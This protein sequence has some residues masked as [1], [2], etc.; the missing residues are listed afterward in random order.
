MWN[1]TSRDS[2]TVNLMNGSSPV[3]LTKIRHCYHYCFQ[4]KSLRVLGGS[5]QEA[6][7]LEAIFKISKSEMVTEM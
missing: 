6:P 1:C 4:E 2:N 3:N 5:I 7:L